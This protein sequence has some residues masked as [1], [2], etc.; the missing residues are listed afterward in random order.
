MPNHVVNILTISGDAD[1]VA[2]IK[3]KISSS[4]DG[5]TLHIDFNKVAP[6]PDDLKGTTS[7]TRIISQKDYDKQEA[8]IASGD[9]EEYEKRFGLSRGITQEMS[10]EFKKKYGTNNWYD[11][12]RN[13]WGTKWNAY[14]QKL[15]ENGDIKFETAW[16]TPARLI[17]KLSNQYPNA[18]FRVR[19]ADENIGFNVGEYSFKNGYVIEENIPHGGSEEACLL[20]CDIRD[21]WDYITS[22]LEEVDN[23]EDLK[24]GWAKNYAMVAY[25][26]SLFGDYQKFVWDYMEKIA[27]EHED[28]EMAHK[29]KQ[30]LELSN[31]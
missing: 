29:I 16:S 14:G 10:V 21:D 22:S 17:Q 23:E 7:P 19:Y 11:W 12:Q 26:K 18:T 8:R 6:L 3:S 13:E 9:L 27:V 20:A 1:L 2:E 31:V 25:K 4:E 5:F 28:Y 30:H 24:K 15:R